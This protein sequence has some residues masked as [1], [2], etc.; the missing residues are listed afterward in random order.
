[1]FF[2]Q[3]LCELL[4]EHSLCDAPEIVDVVL[5]GTGVCAPG[6]EFDRKRADGGVDHW[7][8]LWRKI[9]SRFGIEMAMQDQNGRI[10]NGEFFD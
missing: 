10:M 7:K 2:L 6:D 5:S 3:Q 9:G 4:P 8:V 1:M